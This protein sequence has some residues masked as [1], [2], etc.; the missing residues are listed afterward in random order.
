MRHQGGIIMAKSTQQKP[1]EVAPWANNAYKARIAK[2]AREAK[3]N[4][5]CLIK[6]A[7]IISWFV[8]FAIGNNL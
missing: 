3:Q 1:L 8:L 7:L 4:K 5:E 6:L 2:D